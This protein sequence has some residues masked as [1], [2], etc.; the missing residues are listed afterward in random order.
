MK[1][2]VEGSIASGK[3]TL[4]NRLLKEL[5]ELYKDDKL[6]LIWK[7]NDIL[8]YIPQDE[9]D[10]EYES[11]DENAS[12][13]LTH[14]L[15]IKPLDIPNPFLQKKKEIK[16]VNITNINST[17]LNKALEKYNIDFKESHFDNESKKENTS[18]KTPTK[19]WTGVYN[20]NVFDS[21]KIFFNKENPVDEFSNFIK[22]PTEWCFYTSTYF[23]KKTIS[24]T[25]Y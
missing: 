22:N 4:I 5:E 8:N 19:K 20:I 11:E 1:I 6:I 10:D 17:V 12:G 18:L 15:Q 2:V 24:S 25:I 14:Y 9:S 3:T 16:F 23:L 21:G 13:D 7:E